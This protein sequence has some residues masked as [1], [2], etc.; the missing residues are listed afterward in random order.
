MRTVNRLLKR[1]KAVVGRAFGVNSAVLPRQAAT[2]SAAIVGTAASAGRHFNWYSAVRETIAVQRAAG[3]PKGVPIP[4]G[5][6]ECQ[7]M[8]TEAS[9]PVPMQ[10]A[11]RSSAP[12]AEPGA[13]QQSFVP[14]S[15]VSK[16]GTGLRAATRTGGAHASLGV[17]TR[18]STPWQCFSVTTGSARIAGVIR[19]RSCK[20]RGC[21]TH[22]RL[23]TP[24]PC[25]PVG[26]ILWQTAAACATAAT[27]PKVPHTH[28]RPYRQTT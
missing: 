3:W 2:K 24:S 27:Y 19:R 23:T 15:A 10:S 1:P 14:S 22:P 11:A 25:L 17:T 13:S 7:R 6:A 5:G 26:R 16:S 12:T 21:Q 4:N 8:W 28:A 9:G 20:V 18:R